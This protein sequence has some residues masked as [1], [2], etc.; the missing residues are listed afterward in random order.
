MH[1]EGWENSNI[2]SP[3]TSHADS[4]ARVAGAERG[5]KWKATL[6]ISARVRR[7]LNGEVETAVP[8]PEFR[9]LLC[10]CCFFLK[11]N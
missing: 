7:K 8:E 2:L 1:P 6:G 10:C 4:K 5:H 11:Q 3:S 9:G